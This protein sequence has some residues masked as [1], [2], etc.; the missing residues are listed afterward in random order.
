MLTQQM[1]IYCGKKTNV[2]CLIWRITSTFSLSPTAN[3]WLFHFCR[4][5]LLAFQRKL[6]HLV[7]QSET[8]GAESLTTDV[9]NFPQLC[10]VCCAQIKRQTCDIPCFWTRAVTTTKNPAACDPPLLVPPRCC[11]GHLPHA[12]G[13]CCL[14][15]R[16][17][18]IFTRLFHIPISD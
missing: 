4:R 5:K 11:T 1:D 18:S 14:L 17:C 13:N 2:V 16:S 9:T 6:S 3:G 12:Q 8:G 10:C 15:R 7:S